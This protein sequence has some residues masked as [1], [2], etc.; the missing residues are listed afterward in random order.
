MIAITKR[1]LL[2]LQML[3]RNPDP[4]PVRNLAEQL[5]VSE[6]TVRYD[7]S[8]LE[9]WLKERDVRLKRVP[10]KGVCF[11]T[12]NREKAWEILQE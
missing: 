4:V 11:D 12:K 2:L 10:Q 6:R 1:C 9:D 8:L 3:C 7:L 5:G